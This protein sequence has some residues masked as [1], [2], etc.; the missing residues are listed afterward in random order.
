[1]DWEAI[2]ITIVEFMTTYGLKLVGAIITLIIGFWVIRIIGKVLRKIF[3]KSKMDESLR[4]FLVSLV[5]I[6]LKVLLLIT[7][8]SMLGI[9][10]TS[11][12]A[13]I[14]AIGL[15]IGF[16]LQG[17]LANFAGGVLILFFK[18]FK[19][20]DF[21]E[22]NGY[23]GTVKEIQIINTILNTPDNKVII[24]PNGPLASSV[25]TNFSREKTRRVDLTFGVGYE[26]DIREVKKVLEDIVQNHEK[27][28]KEPAPLIRVAEL[29][30]S[31]VNF[32]VKVW[33]NAAD[34]WSV[35]F[36]LHEQVK[37]VFDEKGISIPFPQVD[38]HMQ[39]ES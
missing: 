32:A 13:L 26:A 34:Y 8:L 38:V 37:L 24:M 4:G 35:Y 1:M 25:I 10:M 11:F 31:S 23:M 17:T 2:K 16:A 21:I 9:E 14:G 15:A 28:L 7:V 19:V 30:D 39:K 12:V 5:T 6:L 36:D 33:V 3:E 20:G 22:A 29:A 18:P 27:V